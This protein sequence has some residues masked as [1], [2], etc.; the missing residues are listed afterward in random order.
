MFLSTLATHAL[1]SGQF[2]LAADRSDQLKSI[3]RVEDH[4]RPF[5]ELGADPLASVL[6]ADAHVASR[7]GDPDAARAAMSQAQAKST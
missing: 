6:S 3:Y 5:L 1:Y 7:R 4:G 2:D